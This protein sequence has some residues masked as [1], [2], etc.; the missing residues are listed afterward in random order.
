MVATRDIGVKAAELLDRLEFHGQSVVELVGPRPVTLNE[1][2]AIL[3]RAIGKPDLKY[4]Q[5]SYDEAAKA[6]LGMGLKPSIVGLMIEMQK[7]FN[8]NQIIPESRLA[9]APTS[10]EAF[11]EVFAQA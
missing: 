5:F 3:G 11:T 2:T 4:V 7:S 1:A 8:E 6:M 9:V 10:F